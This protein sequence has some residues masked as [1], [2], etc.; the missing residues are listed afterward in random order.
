[1]INGRRVPG[2][3]GTQNTLVSRGKDQKNTLV[4]RG[5]DLKNTLVSSVKFKGKA[6]ID[7]GSSLMLGPSEQIIALTKAIRGSCGKGTR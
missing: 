4:S 5:K 3:E 6:A 1:M 7:T 2:L